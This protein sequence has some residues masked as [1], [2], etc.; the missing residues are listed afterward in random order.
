[1]ALER[2]LALFPALST[3]GKIFRYQERRWG[4]L[5]EWT[6]WQGRRTSERLV[7]GARAV[8]RGLAEEAGRRFQTV[9]QSMLVFERKAS[10][11]DSTVE[12]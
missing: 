5:G 2:Y 3:L 7:T 10:A 11:G 4:E 1:M 9:H 8:Y 12:P 6:G